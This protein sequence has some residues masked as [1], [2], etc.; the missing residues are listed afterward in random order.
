ML[1]LFMHAHLL[2][3]IFL[4]FLL[5]YFLFFIFLLHACANARV[6]L[7]RASELKFTCTEPMLI[8]FTNGKKQRFAYLVVLETEDA[9]SADGSSPM[10]SLLSSFCAHFV[11]VSSSF[12]SAT[13]ETKKMME[14]PACCEL[15]V[16]SGFSAGTKTMAKTNTPRCVS[17]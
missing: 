17:P 9:C 16:D 7:H 1:F 11:C 6:L 4:F 8:K 2:F 12:F 13:F 5:F 10:V 15:V 14:W 3:F